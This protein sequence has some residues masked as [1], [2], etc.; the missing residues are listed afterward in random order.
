MLLTQTARQ[1]RNPQVAPCRQRR[2]GA[3][4][5]SEAARRQRAARELRAELARSR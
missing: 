1:P 3:H 2:A 4:R 5:A